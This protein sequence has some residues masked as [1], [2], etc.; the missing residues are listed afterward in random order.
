VWAVVDGT[1]VTPPAPPAIAG[2]AR[3]YV[4]EHPDLGFEVRVDRLPWAALEDADE[5][6]LTNAFAGAVAARG[7]R[8][9]LGEQVALLFRELWSWPGLT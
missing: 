3:R 6:F 9:P 1:L 4:L 5:V 2:V 7:R 8:G